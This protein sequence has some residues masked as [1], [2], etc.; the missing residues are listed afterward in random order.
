M[1]FF[2]D[3]L[4]KE[5]SA[6]VIGLR[7]RWIEVQSGRQIAQ[8]RVPVGELEEAARPMKARFGVRRVDAQQLRKVLY[9]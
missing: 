1:S 3:S 4:S 8:S 9:C 7:M 5:A 2:R 6:I